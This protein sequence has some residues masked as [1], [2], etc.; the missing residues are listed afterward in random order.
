MWCQFQRHFIL[1]IIIFSSSG[2][3]IKNQ[4][5]RTTISGGKFTGIYETEASA[6]FNGITSNKPITVTG[7]SFTKFRMPVYPDGETAGSVIKDNKFDTCFKVEVKAD[8]LDSITLINNTFAN[9]LASSDIVITG[10]ATE[11]IA[12][13]VSEANYDCKVAYGKSSIYPE[14]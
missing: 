10:D 13:S 8:E 12:K 9:G 2:V 14:A 7:A 3:L 5:E 1:V 6:K 4:G 11:D